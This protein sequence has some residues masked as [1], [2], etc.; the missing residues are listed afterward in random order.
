MINCTLL[1]YYAVTLNIGRDLQYVDLANGYALKV[2]A[3]LGICCNL[4]VTCPLITFA[5]RDMGFKFLSISDETASM[6]TKMLAVLG[7]V[8]TALVLSITLSSSFAMLCSLIGA[9]VGIT[10]SII[11]P[12][13]FYHAV[14]SSEHTNLATWALHACILV[15]ALSAASTGVYSDSLSIFHGLYHPQ[16]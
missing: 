6:R 15:I 2:A 7:I 10:N 16:L 5:I 4:Q 9:L 14:H 1:C 8:L 3:A 11:F 12:I 13:V